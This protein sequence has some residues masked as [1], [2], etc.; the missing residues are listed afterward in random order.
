MA[1]PNFARMG[2]KTGLA[3]SVFN[4]AISVGCSELGIA[5]R[6]AE[7]DIAFIIADCCCNIAFMVA[8]FC[9]A[10][11]SAEF[12]AFMAAEFC[13]AVPSAEPVVALAV[14]EVFVTLP[15]AES[16]EAGGGIAG[17]ADNPCF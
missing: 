17:N 12:V 16:A 10:V 4:C 9:V 13:V 3:K 1:F 14:V 5:C 11:P 7:G 6:R 2:A 8:E 15:L